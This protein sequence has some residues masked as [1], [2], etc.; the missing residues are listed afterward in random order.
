MA[1]TLALAD[2]HHCDMLKDACIEFMACPSVMDAV[3]ATQ[4]YKNLKRT[5]PSVVVEV[6]EK[7]SRFRKGWI[8]HLKF[9]L[10]VEN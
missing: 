10:S 9:S 2:Q 1:T 7:I 5:C 3:E 6:L 8:A 4:G